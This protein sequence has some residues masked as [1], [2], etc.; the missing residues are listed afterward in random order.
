M[1]VNPHDRDNPPRDRAALEDIPHLTRKICSIWGTPELDIFLSS[2][3][4][5]SR[6]GARQGLPLQVAAEILFLAR[7]NKLVRAIDLTKKLNIDFEQ[8]YRLVDEGDQ[9]RLKSDAMDDPAVSRDTVT[10]PSRS[11]EVPARAAAVARNGGQAQGLGELLLMLVR[12]KWLAWAIIAVLG[13][14]FVWP[15]LKA[16]F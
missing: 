10:R 4:M 5:D 13:A 1:T 7:T 16:A 9:A 6:D 3:I 11:A 8:A 14:K 12:N 15:A 2:L